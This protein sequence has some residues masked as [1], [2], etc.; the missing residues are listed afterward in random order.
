MFSKILF[1]NIFNQGK[2]ELLD[3]IEKRDKVNI[4]S[5]NPEIL[6]S[7]L[8]NDILKECFTDKTALIIPDGIGTVI[9]SKLVN[10]P[11]KEKIAGIEVMDLII[12]KAYKEN[13]GIYLV[14][15]KKEIIEKCIY[16][17]KEKY[18]HLNILGH[19]D[20]Y[21]SMDNCEEIIEDI[22]NKKPYALFVAMGCPRQ[23]TF[24]WRNINELPCKVFMGVGGSF[25]VLSG[26]TSRAPEFM[27]NMG[28]EWLYRTFKEPFRIKRLFVIPKFI[29]KVCFYKKGGRG[30]EK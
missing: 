3:E 27:I 7:G 21:F 18:E 6:Y 26:N 8:Y 23:E 28:L 9:S 13:K 30:C 5:G 1:Y 20:G 24:I 22:K 17:L 29:I 14:G 25:D 15:A 12:E 10:Q 19:H 11:V 2:K 4:I 16:N